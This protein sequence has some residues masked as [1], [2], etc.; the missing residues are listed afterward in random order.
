LLVGW[1]TVSILVW[2]NKKSEPINS[3]DFIWYGLAHHDRGS[4]NYH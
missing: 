4:Y 2:V 3:S 1:L